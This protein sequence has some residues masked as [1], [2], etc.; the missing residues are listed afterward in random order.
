MWMEEDVGERINHLRTQ[1]AID[2]GAD[3]LCVSCPFCLIMLDD[4][5]KEKGVEE[6]MRVLDISQLVAGAM[7]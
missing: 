3:L 1:E 2:S 4:G 6:S 5:L 7:R